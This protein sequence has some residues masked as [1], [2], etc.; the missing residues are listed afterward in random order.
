MPSTRE[1]RVLIVGGGPSG[2]ACGIEL[3]RQ[4]A[5]VRVFERGAPHREKVCGDGLNFDTQK[6]L[7]RLGLFDAV[8]KKALAIPRAVI[9]GYRGEEI[10]I[11]ETFLT[12]QR[13]EFDQILRDSVEASG[14][15][16]RYE[17]RIDQVQVASDGVC[18]RDR[19]GNTCE[20][21]VLVLAT[22]VRTKLAESLG[23]AFRFRSA[24]A[25]R[26][27][28][29][30]VHGVNAYLFWL[31]RDVSPGYAWAFP[32]P[33]GTLNLGVVN[34]ESGRPERGLHEQLRA[35]T[36][37]TARRIIDDADF[38]RRPKGYTLRTG[39][40]RQPN[41]A[42][43]VLL[44]GE[45]VD[46]TYDLSGEGIGKA[47]ESGLLAAETIL[48]ASHPYGCEALAP[49]QQQLMETCAR[50]HNGYRTAMAVMRHSAGNFFFTK[51]LAHSAKARTALAA[52]IKEEQYPD[53]LFSARGL[54]KTL[55][56]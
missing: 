41:Y 25:L 1:P 39:L 51:L 19:V 21:D 29:P 40:R 27:Y 36:Q 46:C 8:R 35:F 16:V 18:V 56:F 43:R 37:Q 2:A 31:S 26:G 45:N 34:F 6:A 47:M 15:R 53:V 10:P 22:G 49:Y 11:A 54:L 7:K 32:C 5:E 50:F 24:V 9:Y 55:L 52:I 44:V 30:N 23:F 48:Q 42:D 14:G 12:L 13:S 33:D 17:T 4:G 38:V 28:V 3:A 20:G